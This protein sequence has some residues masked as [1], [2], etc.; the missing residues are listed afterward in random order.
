M[1]N[2]ISSLRDLVEEIKVAKAKANTGRMNYRD[3]FDCRNLL[4]TLCA[5]D[6]GWSIEGSPRLVR[7]FTGHTEST[8]RFSRK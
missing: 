4:L 3:Q 2:P 8:I 1:I 7:Q 6:A 5:L